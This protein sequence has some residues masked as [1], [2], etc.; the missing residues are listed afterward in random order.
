MSDR[1][2]EWPF[3][4]SNS[5]DSYLFVSDPVSGMV[6]NGGKNVTYNTFCFNQIQKELAN[7]HSTLSALEQDPALFEQRDNF[8]LHLFECQMEENSD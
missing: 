4:S 2:P 7:L 1:S 3:F 6:G 8:F 5:V